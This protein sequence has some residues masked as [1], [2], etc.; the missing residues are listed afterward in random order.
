MWD[1]EWTD[2]LEHCN[3]SSWLTK[4]IFTRGMFEPGRVEKC[5]RVLVRVLALPRNSCSH[6]GGL[7]T[8][9]LAFRA[10]REYLKTI[11]NFLLA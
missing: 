8:A 7:I 6:T 3:S 4:L 9:L 10:T 11:V 5:V 1:A 2:S